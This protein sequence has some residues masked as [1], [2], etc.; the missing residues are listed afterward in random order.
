MAF[1]ACGGGGSPAVDTTA[2]T[3]PAGVT[4]SVV[5]A[6]QINLSWTAATDNVGVTGYRVERCQ[7]AGCANFAQVGTPTTTSFSDT[8]LA[9]ATSYSYRV[10][11]VD[12]AG[13]AGSYSLVAT[14]TTSAASDTTPPTAPTNLVATAASGTQINLSWAASTDNVG[15]TGYR[16]E[17]CKGTGCANFAQVGTPTATSFNDTGLTDATS[18]SYRVRATDAANNL[19]SYSNV[20]AAATPDV[21]PPTAP[22]NMGATPAS[23]TQIN[24]AWIPSTDNVGVTGY[25]V[26]RCQGAGCSNF[27]QVGTPATT[28]F[29]DTGLSASTP[30]SYRVR[31]TDAANNLS[32]YSGVA[33]AATPPSGVILVT[34]SP[35]RGGMPVSQTM[36]FTV[37]VANDVGAQGVTWSASSGTFTGS[38][39]TQTTYQAPSSA[40]SVTITATSVAD[41]TKT[42]SATI[43]VTDL[44]GV[45]TYHNDLSRDGVNSQEYALTLANVNTTTFG[46][47]FSCTTDGAIYGQPLWVPGL[48]V[49]G[50]KHNVVFVA[51]Q[52]DSLYAFD[53]DLNTSPCVPLWQVSL[54]DTMHGGASGETS[55]PSGTSGNLVG[56]GAGDI[57]PEV[58]ILGTPVIDLGSKILYAVSK[59]VDSTGT[60][61]VQRLHGI[62]LATGNEKLNGA[63]VVISASFPGDGDGSSGGLIPFNPQTQNQRPAL[64]L[65]NG[66]VYV[67]WGSHEDVDPYHGWLIAYRAT[68]LTQVA[69]FNSTPNQATGFIHSR[70]GIWMG[71][72]APAADSSNNLYL[73]TGNGAYDGNTDFGDSVVRLSTISGLTAVDWFTPMDQQIL[74]DNDMDFGSGGTVVLADLPMAPVQ[75][76]LIGGGKAGDL[77][78]LNRD[79]LGHFTTDNHTAIQFFAAS[80]EIFATPAY[81]QNNVYYAGSGVLGAGDALSAFT[82]D[83]ISGTFVPAAPSM[84]SAHIFPFPGATPSI[85]W[86]GTSNPATSNAIV[87][88]LDNHA[89]CTSQS[90]ACGPAV[91]Y[92]YD[93]TNLAAELWNSSTTGSDDAGFAVKFTV[94]TVAN[95]KVYI[96]TRGSDDG[97]YTSSNRGELDVYG[98]KPN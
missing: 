4:T 68:D 73:I 38:T 31:A 44:T 59:S 3:A 18:Y 66:M 43:G 35:V 42:A 54:I 58:G 50:D 39:A 72:G 45:T 82:L 22:G 20:A 77:F 47:L 11:A 85:S 69:A 92:A 55:V 27:A 37:T 24:L 15:V 2:P 75:H 51:T 25:F 95:G 83:P 36:P 1:E 88:A 70:G 26:E 29:I 60:N 9:A 46:K 30:Y 91:L 17:R 76:V 74:N 98:L 97:S 57:T 79:M 78:L 96:G 5:S 67:G 65:V 63:P 94:P 93:A 10:R 52:H 80:G 28:S 81:W 53:A 23:S 40:G 61:I 56:L 8:G 34:I 6:T 14:A 86:N 87:W 41:S 12:A 32:Q 16:V 62:D 13:N 48:T 71:G 49:N 89:Y 33:T 21:T 7:G 19:S 84:K 90:S 64:A